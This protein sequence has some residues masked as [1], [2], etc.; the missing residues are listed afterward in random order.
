MR[1]S[2][3]A[4]VLF[5][6]AQLAIAQDPVDFQREVRPILADNCFHCHGPDESSRQVELRLDL[7]EGILEKRPSG[8]PIVPGDPDASL[9]Y[10][11]ISHEVE[12]V[13]M[14]PP[15]MSDKR[16]TDEE[17][18][19]LRRWIVEGAGWDQHWSF[20]PVA[21]VEPPA[22]SDSAWAR[23]PIDRFILAALDAEGL[24]PAPE[25]DKHALARRVALDLT[26]LPPDPGTL[27]SFL[28]DDSEQAY[29]KL[30]DELLASKHYG[31][32]RARYW[33]DAARYGDTHGVHID[34]YREMYFYRDWVI[35]AFN[36]NKPFDEFTLEQLAGDLLPDP[37]L[38]QL[39]ATGFHRNNITTN[40]GGAIPEEWEA[41]YAKDRADTTS[42]VFLGLTAGCATCHDHKFDPIAQ[43][44]FYALTAFFRNTTQYV[45]DGNVS[46]PP[47][48]LVVPAD[49]D[50]DRWHELRER[51]AEI[52]SKLE[53]RTSAVETA[54]SD[55]LATEAYRSIETPLEAAAELLTLDLDDAPSVVVD[56]ARSPIE[57]QDG[58]EV[59][60]GPGG[61]RALT[62]GETSWTELPP[63][64][65]DGET[66]FSMSFW[67][68]SPENQEN[69]IIA[70]QHDPDDALRGWSLSIGA[71][72]M[73]F[74][75]KGDDPPEGER[76]TISVY[77]INT[78]RLEEGVW[79]H[80]IVTYDGSGERAGVRIYPNGESVELEGS[81]YFTAIDGEILTDAPL[82]LGRGTTISEVDGRETRH[83][84]GGRL[85]DFRVFNRRLT[86]AEVR[87]LARWPVLKR[88]RAKAPSE[89]SDDERDAL[90]YYYLAVEDDATHDLSARKYELDREWR[91]IRRRSGV[92]HVMHEKTD[93][94]P[95]AYVLFRGMYD[96]K[97]DH[98]LAGTPAVLPPM[99][100]TLPRNRLGLAKWLVDDAHPLTSRVIVNRYWQQVFG[101]GLVRTSED[102]GAQGEL[103]SHPELLD[104]LAA[105]YR[106]SGWDTKKFFSH[107]RD[108]VG[109]PAVGA[110]GAS[111]DRPRS[112]EPSALPG[113]S[114]PHGRGDDPGL[115]ARGERPSRANDWR[116]EREAVSAGGCV[117]KR[118]RCRRAT[119]ASTSGIRA[120]GSIAEASIHFGS[121]PPR[122]RRWISSTHRLGSTRRYGASERT[123]RFRRS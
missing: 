44:E 10:Q 62:F 96:Q 90:A 78:K 51:S 91:E 64:G 55:W 8:Q 6:I 37:T 72:L 40:E 22:V 56:G 30:V 84:T 119:P 109:V 97:R 75:M 25:A 68:F 49:E 86:P 76:R 14:P 48:V 81:E 11:R 20:V 63:L 104:W 29:E 100:E 92:T 43:K 41:V 47:P 108:V 118:L 101:A 54:F 13:R 36:D 5:A 9:L 34:N 33:L 112:G 46:D 105:E 7:E 53:G 23:N 50:R 31:E 52:D 45:M 83:F 26:G 66:P 4:L 39:I 12:A 122:P 94:V 115:G 110:G 59:G 74:R 113:A 114:L 88:A 103:P 16:L 102:F 24:K 99:D 93:G 98:V 117:G 120:T 18:D 28:N 67:L 2:L 1:L 73:T 19:V 85:A 17:V 60:D 3:P 80:I 65:L 87:V 82:Y 107:A 69:V 35:D 42:A 32:H 123:R 15:H 70:S 116:A 121:A 111:Q 77:P 38:E 58:V 89:L 21:A 79:T 61:E 106:T 57:L 27:A 95:E 71:R